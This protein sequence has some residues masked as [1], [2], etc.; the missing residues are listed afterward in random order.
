MTSYDRETHSASDRLAA[1]LSTFGGHVVDGLEAI[2]DL[3]RSAIE[4][5]GNKVR[6]DLRSQG[7][8][9]DRIESQ[10]VTSAELSVTEAERLADLAVAMREIGHVPDVHPHTAQ[11]AADPSATVGAMS[12]LQARAEALTIAVRDDVLGVFSELQADLRSFRLQ[13]E[14]LREEVEALREEFDNG[15]SPA[16]MSADKEA[17]LG[18]LATEVRLLRRRFQL[19]AGQDGAGQ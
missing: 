3:V 15:A 13:L 10:L 4:D 16:S 6:E 9:L 19:Q 1:E 2:R 5:L 12:D 18:R 14:G 11:P 17:E 7:R 8:R